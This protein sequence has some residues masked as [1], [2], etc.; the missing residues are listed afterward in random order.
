MMFGIG[1]RQTTTEV[2]IACQQACKCL[3]TIVGRKHNVDNSLCSRNY[4]VN[5]PRTTFVENQYNRFTG[6]IK[7]VHQIYLIRRQ[8]EVV[9]I[10]LSLAVTG[11]TDTS[12]D[13]VNILGGSYNLVE[14]PDMFHTPVTDPLIGKTIGHARFIDNIIFAETILHGSK[15]SLVVLRYGK[16][17]SHVAL[18]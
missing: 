4:R 6:S 8:V 11:F 16:F 14:I 17:I 12:Y 3:T 15:N 10:P 2:L 9:D 5:K 7:A 13:N 1:E 18:P